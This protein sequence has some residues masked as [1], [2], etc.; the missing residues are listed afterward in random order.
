[1]CMSM[2]GWIREKEDWVHDC[3]SLQKLAMD[4]QCI[5]WCG[6]GNIPCGP[7]SQSLTMTCDGPERS[8]VGFWLELAF[9]VSGSEGP[10]VSFRAALQE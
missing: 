5:V 2:A 3:N 1:M 4:W 6:E 7:V 10:G 9:Q 8:H